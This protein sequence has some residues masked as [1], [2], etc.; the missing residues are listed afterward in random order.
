VKILRDAMRQA[1]KEP[2][3]VNAHA[4]LDS[5]VAYLD[6][7]EFN[8]FWDKDARRLTEVVKAIGKVES[9]Q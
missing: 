4:K 3:V 7:D 8:A 5:P 6:A 9:A 1:V 2:E